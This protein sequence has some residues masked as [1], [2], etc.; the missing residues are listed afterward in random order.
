MIKVPGFTVSHLLGRGTYGLVYMGKKFG[1]CKLVAIKCMMKSRLGKQA[2]DNLVSEI[3]ILKTLE[4]PHIVCMLDFTWDASYVYIIMEFCGGGDL[5][6]FLKQKRKLDELLVQ[7]FLQQLALA[8][9]Y[10]KSK[11]IIHM[12]LKPQNILLTSFN[13]PTLKLADFGF[14]KCIEGTAHMNEVRGTLLYMAPEIYCEGV[15]HP[16]CDLWSVGIILYECLF[17][18]PPY[19]NANIQQLKEILVKDDP[20]EV[21]QTNEIS[22]PCAALIRDLLK[23]K[24]SERL[25]HEQFFSHPFID[26]D[27]I[28]SAQS[29]DKANEYLERAPKLESLGKLCEAYDC[30]LEGLN[31]LVAACNY[32]QSRF[33][34]AEIRNL[35]KNYLIKAESLKSELCLITEMNKVSPSST[36]KSHRISC[37][38]NSKDNLPDP[39]T[40][41]KCYRVSQQQQQQL[42]P[43]ETVNSKKTSSSDLRTD[44]KRNS[45]AELKATMY[46]PTPSQTNEITYYLRDQLTINSIDEI[47][48]CLSSDKASVITRV[49]QWFTRQN[50]KD[51]K[52]Y[53]SER[54]K[55]RVPTGLLV[56]VN[57]V[58]SAQLSSASVNSHSLKH[59]SSV[60]PP[61]L[62]Q[63]SSSSGSDTLVDRQTNESLVNSQS[64]NN[65]ALPSVNSIPTDLA[66]SQNSQSAEFGVKVNSV[67]I[68]DDLIQI[69]GRN[70]LLELADNCN[71]DVI[72]FLNRFYRL[73]SERR[74]KEALLYFE[75][76]FAT[77]L[78]AV[79]SDSNPKNRSILYEELKFSMDEAEKIKA[80][81]DSAAETEGFEVGEEAL[82]D[83][84]EQDRC[85]FM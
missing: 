16:S 41:V 14:A 13:N 8:L 59:H 79:K 15:Y 64:D 49:K 78:K 62:N 58:K 52:M 5:G 55:G 11:N 1:S 84:Q 38:N 39:I 44:I 53:E 65:T 63:N 19:G 67:K 12:D 54:N 18:A 20:I 74:H 80:N 46:Y 23:R 61:P 42:Q 57:P 48:D 85:S 73:I 81:L 17:G 83:D 43:K 37:S 50:Y 66:K 71:K 32:E 35:M 45:P 82:D 10:L 21:P 36:S 51:E 24:P 4:H 2:Q 22:K 47:N 30:Y 26:L 7:H 31:H 72:K 25:T 6:R 28:P 75:N 77:C 9:Q 3:S 69:F 29:M 40:P 56:D 60:S 76:E 34:K 33:R 27:H 70:Q 68:E